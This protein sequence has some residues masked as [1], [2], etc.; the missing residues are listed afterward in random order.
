MKNLRY[1]SPPL[2]A[3]RLLR[4]YCA[5]HKLEEIEGD[6]FEE[7]IYQ[8]KHIGLKKA[9][10]NYVMNV[11]RFIK[12]FV[13]KRK[14]SPTS[15]SFL[16][17]NIYKHYLTVAVR[18]LFRQKVFSFIN[19]VGLSLGMVCCLFIFLWVQDEKRVDNFHVH[20]DALYRLYQTTHADGET[21]GSYATPFVTSSGD[22]KEALAVKI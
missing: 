1:P 13:I 19:V 4:W 9:K 14:T 2:W 17:M 10:H 7:F 15:N 21:H 12:P 6:L 16:N 5:P 20:G 8:V 22:F 3:T 18:N 11:F